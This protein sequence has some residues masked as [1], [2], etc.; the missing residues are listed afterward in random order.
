M[1]DTSIFL[2]LGLGEGGET[3]IREGENSNTP[4]PPPLCETLVAPSSIKLIVT[5]LVLLLHV[6][7]DSS[8]SPR[9]NLSPRTGSDVAREIKDF[10]NRFSDLVFK[11]RMEIQDEVEE[12][13]TPYELCATRIRLQNDL[14]SLP[15]SIRA[16][17]YEFI[18]ESIDTI[19]EAKSVHKIFNYLNLYWSFIDCNL[20]EHLIRKFGS[21][22]LQAQM[23]SYIAD[24]V[25]FR[26]ST[27]VAQFAKYWPKFGDKKDPPPHFSELKAKLP[28]DPS[29]CTLEYVENLRIAFCREFLLSKSALVLAGVNSGSVV[30]VWYV[31]SSIS[32]VLSAKLKYY[33]G[34]IF[35]DYGV[36]E[37]Y[38][39]S[40]SFNNLCGIQRQAEARQGCST[41][42]EQVS[43]VF[44][45]CREA[46][47][48]TV[49][50]QFSGHQWHFVQ[51]SEVHLS[52][53]CMI[54]YR[55]FVSI[56]D[57]EV[58]L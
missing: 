50:P 29:C 12:R 4:P 57:V 56:G 2:R 9:D 41:E 38:L 22:G 37:L 18:M 36:M 46:V 23:T 32:P 47:T 1:C 40:E 24:L 3:L 28:A 14:T 48:V 55:G 45:Y 58:S 7:T 16:D 25:R 17:H 35:Q 10:E 43:A 5:F 27:T 6:C 31:P 49:E 26:K 13:Q 8:S 15:A 30:V 52:Q 51:Y 21:E 39:G 11:V 19:S 33:R 53:G 54:T 34:T 20:L 42:L 44:S